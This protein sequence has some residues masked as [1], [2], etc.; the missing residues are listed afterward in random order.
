MLLWSV[1]MTIRELMAC[2]LH[3]SV[4]TGSVFTGIMTV[5]ILLFIFY[6]YS[7]FLGSVQSW[8]ITKAHAFS[9]ILQWKAPRYQFPLVQTWMIIVLILYVL[10]LVRIALKVMSQGS[11]SLSC[12]VLSRS[13]SGFA[14]FSVQLAWKV[15]LWILHW[16]SISYR[17][18]AVASCVFI[19]LF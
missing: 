15:E 3:N 11:G 6:F 1:A 12:D 2:G 18:Y 16:F 19:T 10:S 9:Y 4:K 17:R 7:S 8:E 13:R 14:C 5:L